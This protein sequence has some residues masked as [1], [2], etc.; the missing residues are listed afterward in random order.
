MIVSELFAS[1]G[2]KWDKRAEVRANQSMGRFVKGADKK[3]SGFATSAVRALAGVATATAAVFQGLDALKF[4]EQIGRLNITAKGT[5]G[6]FDELSGK[7][8]KVSSEFG[9]AKEQVA[10]G[11]AKFIELTGKADV[12]AQ[13]MG[14]FAEVSQ[15]TGASMDEV[16]GAAAGVSEQLD[17]ASSDFRMMFD[18]LAEG[19]KAGAVELRDMAS[20]MSDLAA[21][22][23]RF[24]DSKG[25][26]TVEQLGAALQLATGLKGGKAS[27]GATALKSLLGTFGQD[28]FNKVMAKT[29][30]GRKNFS[31]DDNGKLRNWVDIIKELEGM[32]LTDIE[33]GKIFTKKE[34]ADGFAALTR[35]SGQW[36]ELIAKTQK[37]NTIAKDNAKIAKND[38]IKV[39]KAWIRFKN[40]L[41]KGFMQVVKVFGFLA[42]HTD[43]LVVSLVSLGIAYAALNA[44]ASAAALEMFAKS[45]LATAGW[46][47]VGAVIAALILL[48]VDFVETLQGKD[49]LLRRFWE[50]IVGDWKEDLYQ[51]FLWLERKFNDINKS[52]AAEVADT[53]SFLPGVT[54]K[55]DHKANLDFIDKVG[56]VM[57]LPDN[58]KI[59]R[60]RSDLQADTAFEFGAGGSARNKVA[61]ESGFPLAAENLTFNIVEA[62]N[63]QS[64]ANAVAEIVTSI[65]TGTE[66]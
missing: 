27:E 11:T 32:N 55:A 50:N 52:I 18:I 56:K 7:V 3:V 19:G 2:L 10:A 45:L 38:A 25:L 23:A 59:D 39:T 54:S 21:S 44:A 37:A 49:T 16:A 17:I 57:R 35:Q 46:L 47:L 63:A 22:T 13:N 42:E 20:V 66:E 24:A 26:G 33:I 8:L 64:T 14:L 58:L 31:F 65:Q 62:G 29:K 41:T 48:F 51:F 28:R 60:M 5:L 15:A 6:S 53:F 4:T 40:L 12:A 61:L 43:L 9:I 1:L 30:G 36:D 34:A